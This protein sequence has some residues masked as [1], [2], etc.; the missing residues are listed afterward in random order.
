M[1][2][3]NISELGD[4][5]WPAQD[6]KCFDHLSV[7]WTDV[8]RSFPYV[9]DFTACIQAGGNVGVWPRYLSR[10]FKTV[11]TFEPNCEN[12]FY[13]SQNVP[14]LS[15]VKLNAALGA[16][17]GLVQTTLSAR[18]AANIGAYQVEDGGIVPTFTIDQLVLPACGLIALDIEGYELFALQGGIE[19][20]KRCKPIIHLEDKG[21]S[22]KYGVEKGEAIDFLA[23]LGYEVVESF[24]RDFICAPLSA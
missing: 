16:R 15:V 24:N 18:E 2:K 22:N 1:R 4:F 23:T 8:K 20:I 12:F 21:L 17:G 10:H 5:F 3:L 6:T 19:T 14:E 9:K 7:L 13:L 11:Y